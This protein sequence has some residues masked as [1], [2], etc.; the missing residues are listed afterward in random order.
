MPTSYEPLTPQQRERQRKV[1]SSMVPGTG[2]AKR[3]AVT[4][5]QRRQKQTGRLAEIMGQ[6][7]KS[8]GK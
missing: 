1:N 3:A 6:I 8:R 7:R 5:E 2:A 4:V